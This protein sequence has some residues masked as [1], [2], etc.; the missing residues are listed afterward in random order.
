MRVRPCRPV[1]LCEQEGN[2]PFICRTCCGYRHVV[3][4]GMILA[5]TET[6]GKRKEGRRQD[7]GRL[8]SSF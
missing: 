4:F 7:E 6:I 8:C 1:K 3:F 2:L 5:Y